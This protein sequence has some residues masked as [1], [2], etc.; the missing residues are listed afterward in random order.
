M[1]EQLNPRFLEKYVRFYGF[2]IKL[3][4]LMDYGI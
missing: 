2:G 1:R 3:L 4:M